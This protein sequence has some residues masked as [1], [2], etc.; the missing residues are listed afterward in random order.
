MDV[1]NSMPNYVYCAFTICVC[2]NFC[3]CFRCMWN[4]KFQQVVSELGLE[5]KFS[6]TKM[7]KKGE[8]VAAKSSIGFAIEPLNGHNDFTLWQQRVKNILTREGYVK[9]LQPKFEKPT[10]LKNGEWQEKKDLTNSMIQ[11]YVGK[12][13]LR[14][15]INETDLTDLWAKARK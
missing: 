15:V 6:H 1:G 12:N 14:E 5:H 9:A 2:V 11:L 3:V 10:N 13:T 7:T 4:Q 8:G